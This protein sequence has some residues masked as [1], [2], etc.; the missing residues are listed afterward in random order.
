ML[1]FKE[2]KKNFIK[3]FFQKFFLKYILKFFIDE[4]NKNLG[5]LVFEPEDFLFI[6]GK[7]YS[8]SFV[9]LAIEF[10]RI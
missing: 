6:I 9:D 3:F 2:V 1:F 4:V 8:V 5:A 7:D 10:T